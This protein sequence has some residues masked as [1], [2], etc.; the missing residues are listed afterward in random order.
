MIPS[1]VGTVNTSPRDT[2]VNRFASGDASHPSTNFVPS[3]HSVRASGKSPSSVTV[4]FE[5]VSVAKSI[6]YKNPP[7]SQVMSLFPSEANLISKSVYVVILRVSFV[8]KS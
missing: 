3:I 2:N 8:V 1:S 7:R 6:T 4:T 5:I